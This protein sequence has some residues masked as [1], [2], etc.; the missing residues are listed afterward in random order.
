MLSTEATRPAKTGPPNRAK[1]GASKEAHTR[2]RYFSRAVGR[3]LEFLQAE[4]KPLTMHEIGQRIQLSKASAFRILGTL[5][6][7]GC[8]TVDGR[9]HYRLAQGPTR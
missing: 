5:E 4:L 1:T 9:G 2:D 3:A 7:L 6:T 8:V